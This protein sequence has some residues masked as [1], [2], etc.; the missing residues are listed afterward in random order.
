MTRIVL[1]VLSTYSVTS[2]WTARFLLNNLL[3]V[4]LAS[5][6]MSKVAFFLLIFYK[7]CRF[8]TIYKVF[9]EFVT[10]LLLFCVLVFWHQGMWGSKIPD[11][12]LNCTPYIGRQSL[13]HWTTKEVLSLA[14][15]K[16]LSLTSDILIIMGLII[17]CKDVFRYYF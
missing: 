1:S 5:A 2:F 16:I 3:I 15:F 4:L 12:K 13:D 10:T 8:G 11:Q 9:I 7:D 6:D 14:A 17:M